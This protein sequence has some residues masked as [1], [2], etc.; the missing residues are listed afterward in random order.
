VKTDEVPAGRSS[1]WPVVHQVYTGVI[2]ILAITI[3]VLLYLRFAPEKRERAEPVPEKS[4]AVL[5]FTNLSSDQQNAF[6]AEGI[7]DDILT[8]LAR[9]AEL[10]VISRNSVSSYQANAPRDTRSIAGALGVAYLLEGSVRGERNHFVVNV[11]LIDARDDRQVWAEHY[12]R[13]LEDSLGLQGE[14]AAEIANTLHATLS[15][16]EKTRVQQKPTNNADA[17]ALYLRASA[18][19]HK[20]DTLLQDYQAAVELYS[21][22]IALDPSFALAHARLASTCAAI[23]HFHE[24]LDNWASKARAESAAALRLDPNLAEGH[25]A[26][27]LCLYWMDQNYEAALA[28]FS[29]AAQLAPND[30]HVVALIAA[31]KR[32]RGR[33]HEAI[34]QYEQAAK[35]DP[36]NPN[37]ARN[38]VYTYSALRD[39]N[40]ASKAAK[41]W[42]QIAPDSLIA[43]IQIGYLDFFIGGGT[44]RLR[45]ILAEIPLDHDPDGVVTAARWDAA[46]IARD[47]PAAEEALRN[48][49]RLTIDY[50][51]GGATP[52]AFLAG[53][54]PLARGD[55]ARSKPLLEKARA[56][57]ADAV[58][59]SPFTAEAHANLGLVDA[60]LGRREEAIAEG[61]RAA[62]LKP[63]E[64]DA[65][66]GAIVLCQLALIYARVGENNQA[67]PLLQRLLQTPGTIDSA[68]YSI[69]PNDLRYRW[70]WDPL[71][72]DARF[73]KLLK[74]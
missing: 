35:L 47:F 5:P 68:D 29:R 39:W 36:R 28:E 72:S 16:E 15:P 31:L 34:S 74:P 42:Q 23:F 66:D 52:R 62:E 20:P 17:Y 56:D 13:K 64:K 67:I 48:S 30:G 58:Q 2:G 59:E 46:M 63:I 53:C 51:N 7:Q 57:F 61:R 50:L 22:A 37:V 24:P 41:R 27:G 19:E 40:Q 1:G 4:I 25:V 32:R 21:Q 54:I 8:S 71:R 45:R 44:Q 9:I 65:V 69:T 43:K 6:F 73:N 49:S 3:A 60:F 26:Q 33:F 12:D 10:K 55:A 11:Q 14:L 70:E 18:L 38:L